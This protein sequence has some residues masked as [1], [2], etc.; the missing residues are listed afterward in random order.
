MEQNIKKKGLK[1]NVSV[2]LQRSEQK[3]WLSGR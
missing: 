1:W 2:Y 3:I